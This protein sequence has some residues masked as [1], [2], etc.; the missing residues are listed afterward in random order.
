M[1]TM[2]TPACNYRGRGADRAEDLE[3]LVAMGTPVCEILARLGFSSAEA[4]RQVA[5]RHGKREA[6]LYLNPHTASERAA[7]AQ[8]R[9]EAGRACQQWTQSTSGTSPD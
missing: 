4:A 6:E 8:K 5:I 7:R 2:Y 3:F 1:T 9:K